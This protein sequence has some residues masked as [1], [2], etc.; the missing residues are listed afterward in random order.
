MINLCLGFR[1]YIFIVAGT[2][3]LSLVER[4]NDLT[5]MYTELTSDLLD[6]VFSQE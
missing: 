3:A 6:P 1:P 2:M 5:T 4:W